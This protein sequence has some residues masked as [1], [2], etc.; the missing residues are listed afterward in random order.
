MDEFKQQ[1]GEQ[2]NRKTPER[3]NSS[4]DDGHADMLRKLITNRPR[5]PEAVPQHSSDYNP[6]EEPSTWLSEAIERESQ[7]GTKRS[8]SEIT[9]IDTDKEDQDLHSDSE[10]QRKKIKTKEDRVETQGEFKKIDKEIL[11]LAKKVREKPIDA[12]SVNLE[13]YGQKMKEFEELGFRLKEYGTRT[14]QR[15]EIVITA[16][17]EVSKIENAIKN[18]ENSIRLTE[19]TITNSSAEID[20]SIQ[21]DLEDPTILLKT[22]LDLLERDKRKLKEDLDLAQRKIKKNLSLLEHDK[23][24]YDINKLKDLHSGSEGYITQLDNILLLRTNDYQNILKHLSTNER[25]TELYSHQEASFS[26]LQSKHPYHPTNRQ[27][28][29]EQMEQPPRALRT[30]KQLR[31]GVN[32]I[33]QALAA[34]PKEKP[35]DILAVQEWR[36]PGNELT[37]EEIDDV[38]RIAVELREH[39]HLDNRVIGKNGSQLCKAIQDAAA[40]SNTENKAKQTESRANWRAKPENRAKQTG[41]HAHYRTKPEN[42]AKRAAKEDKEAAQLEMPS[43]FGHLDIGDLEKNA[44]SVKE[45]VRVLSFSDPEEQS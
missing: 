20:F 24:D 35:Q 40:R 1:G 12:S 10:I 8:R 41:Y 2:E 22:R 15:L 30:E 14:R 32:A 18:K 42:I 25:Q 21:T 29:R 27:S 33:V 3:R 7:T 44:Q 26:T 17:E 23:T 38:K 4:S 9:K 16:A 34:N 36:E 5:L 13:E 37:Q 43:S 45:E 11:A 39:K 31:D 28:L 19:R 6:T